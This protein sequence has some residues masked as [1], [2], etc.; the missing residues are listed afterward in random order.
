MC[1][2]SGREGGGERAGRSCNVCVL[3]AVEKEVERD[4]DEVVTCVF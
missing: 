3:T 1:F 4:L 2:D